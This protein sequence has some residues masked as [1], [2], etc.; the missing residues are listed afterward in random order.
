MEENRKINVDKTLRRGNVKFVHKHLKINENEKRDLD[1]YTNEMDL[2]TLSYFDE[3]EQEKE[4][5][6]GNLIN[7]DDEN[8]RLS[9]AKYIKDMNRKIEYINLTSETGIYI[10]RKLSEIMENSKSILEKNFAIEYLPEG[11]EFLYGKENYE[12]SK[13][14]EF[15]SRNTV[16][17]DYTDDAN[18]LIIY[19]DVDKNSLFKSKVYFENRE[20]EVKEN[21]HIETNDVVDIQDVKEYLNNIIDS[22]DGLIEFFKTNPNILNDLAMK[23]STFRKYLENY[24]DGKITN[25][26]GIFALTKG[27]IEKV[28]KDP[29]LMNNIKIPATPS[30]DNQETEISKNDEDLVI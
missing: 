6:L 18:N 2:L 10:N 3:N 12:P 21:T 7:L 15:I 20:V 9:L 4:F 19:D 17:I 22:V 28:S 1:L 23:D 14:L 11:Y 24:K 25:M 5:I 8:K 26:S 16:S 30:I 27:A 13:D 29:E